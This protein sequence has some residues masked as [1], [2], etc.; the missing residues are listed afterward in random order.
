VSAVKKVSRTKA[1]ELI[2]GTDGKIFSVGFYKKNK[3][4]REMTARLG[5]YSKRK[6]THRKSIAHRLDNS[7]VL[8]FDMQKRRYRM[9]NLDTLMYVKADGEE[10]AIS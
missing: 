3:S 1:I 10:Y 2:K 5:V 7:Y 4:F 8:V 6:T 9:V